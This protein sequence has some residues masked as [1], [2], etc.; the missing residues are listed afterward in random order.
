MAEE[1]EAL[2]SVLK[3]PSLVIGDDTFVDEVR[4]RTIEFQYKH[5]GL[6]Q[7]EMAGVLQL[8]VVPR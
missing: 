3:G 7:R 8:A 1:D 5:A 2:L 6:T 4:S